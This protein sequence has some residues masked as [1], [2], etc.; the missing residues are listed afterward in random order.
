MT[1]LPGLPSDPDDPDQPRRTPAPIKVPDPSS[2]PEHISDQDAGA[3]LL[4]E[5]DESLMRVRAVFVNDAADTRTL[6]YELTARRSGPSGRA[7]RCKNGS[8]AAAPGEGAVLDVLPVSV[9]D[10]DTLVLYLIVRKEGTPVD[11]VRCRHQVSSRAG[12]TAGS[13][14]QGE[15]PAGSG[16]GEERS[17]S[18]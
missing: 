6:T 5:K 11:D 15:G 18:L 2:D 7:K 1:D 9:Q 8:F 14:P 12:E 13:P 10:G 17:R 16:T 3:H 4:V